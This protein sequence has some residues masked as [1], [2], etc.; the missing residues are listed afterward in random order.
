MPSDTVCEAFRRISRAHRKVALQTKGREAAVEAMCKQ[1]TDALSPEMTEHERNQAGQP[2]QI[3]EEMKI[4][5]IVLDRRLI[6]RG[7][8]EQISD[9]AKV[10][11]AI[12]GKLAGCKWGSVTGLLRSPG[13]ALIVSLLRYRCTIVGSGGYEQDPRKLETCVVNEL[14]RRVA[15]VSRSARIP[16]LLAT[17]GFLSARNVYVQ[18]CAA[19]LDLGLRAQNGSLQSRLDGWTQQLYGVDSWEA[20]ILPLTPPEGL[21]PPR[22]HYMPFYDLDMQEFWCHCV[23]KKEPRLPPK[24]LVSSTFHTGA[25]GAEA[26]TGLKEAT[27]NFVNAGSCMDEGIQNLGT[28]K[29][30]IS[31]SF[32]YLIR[33]YGT[34]VSRSKTLLRVKI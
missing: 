16:V 11:L 23:L 28:Y 32:C 8:I 1:Q 17:A 26:N 22:I 31:L 3:V 15:E 20:Q 5:G 7:H 9:R 25:V 18:R 2:Y 4:L 12:L 29:Y 34:S 19:V 24:H 27:Y 33:V 6:F 14:A 30:F 13:E 10:G 21:L